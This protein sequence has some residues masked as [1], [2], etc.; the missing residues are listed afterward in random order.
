M[1]A[2]SGRAALAAAAG[3]LCL[4]GAACGSLQPPGAELA[5]GHPADVRAT[6]L[7]GLRGL[8]VTLVSVR[9]SGRAGTR[10]RWLVLDSGSQSL[11][12]PRRLVEEISL[13]LLGEG[14]VN[15][16][17]TVSFHEAA[18]VEVGPL[19]LRRP[20]VT[21]VD[22]EALGP[23]GELFGGEIGG[24]AGYPVFARTVV[25][26]RYGA[27][28]DRVSIHD[29]GT[30]RLP[31]GG[32]WYPLRLVDERPVAEGHLEDGRPVALMIDT[33]TSGALALD[34][35]L[36]RASGLVGQ[37]AVTSEQ[38]L[39][40]HGRVAVETTRLPSFELGGRRFRDIALTVRSAEPGHQAALP[41]GTAGLVGRELF[42]GLTL[43]LDYPNRRF[44]IVP[45]RHL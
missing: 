13:P 1:R 12:L 42:A 21:A 11:V 9:L 30:F 38:R 4:F 6:S 33:G 15:R 17:T 39:T 26:V 27:A 23:L 18:T 43:I 22:R 16:S 37:G 45:H 10:E 36:A 5:P 31:A 14:V 8:G 28:G 2:L 40:L 29:P 3:L 7:V 34:R 25:E 19:V 44:A 20:V 32:A 35:E 24:L 41:A